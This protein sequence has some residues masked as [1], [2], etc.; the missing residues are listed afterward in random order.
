M[1]GEL[2]RLWLVV[3]AMLGL[4]ISVFV[5]SPFSEQQAA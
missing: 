2:Q 3:V 5:A 4:R 1:L